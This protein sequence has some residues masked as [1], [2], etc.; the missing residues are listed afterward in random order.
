M[1]RA[2]KLLLV[3][4]CLILLSQFPFAYR[5]FKL[6]RLN[7]A[8]QA[9]QTSTV[10]DGL[11]E[12]Q[13]VIHVHSFLG[14]HSSGTFQEI[15]SAARANHLQFVIMTEHAEK[16]IDTA[17]MTLQGMHDGVLFVNGNEVSSATGDRLLTIPGDSSSAEADKISTAEI[18]TRTRARH[19]LS[20]IAYPNE[21][22]SWENGFD[23]IEVYNVFTNAKEYNR[24]VAFFDALWAYSSY[25]DLLFANFYQRP[26]V[27]LKRWDSLLAN[28]KIVATA[29]NDS[30]S[31]I[32]VSLNDSRGKQLAG[33]K[34][35][36][37]TTS[38][39]LVRMHVLLPREQNL[40]SATLL[41]AIRAG[42]CYIG[43]DVLGDTSGFR[44]SAT[45]GASTALQGDEIL[46]QPGTVL[47][48]ST[49][50]KAR[51]LILKNGETQV[52]ES[53][54]QEKEIPISEPGVY[55]VEVYLPQLGKPGGDQPWIISNP[56][57]IR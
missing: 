1:T 27:A 42:H 52:D 25:R 7:I 5:R 8:I 18:A 30:H 6:R 50:A 26:T 13:G 53:D 43:F 39:H 56:I 28:G 20:I 48:I 17:A 29:G 32:G 15:I 38:F 55:R 16:E 14:G 21:F 44:F 51:L 49:P 3:F 2:R 46:L 11:V 23:G 34:L 40:D 36:P 45:N 37:Y 22:K 19:G 41:E 33:I 54:V 31:N 24:L 47:K 4:V 57:F 9:I 10:A 12:Y 35:D